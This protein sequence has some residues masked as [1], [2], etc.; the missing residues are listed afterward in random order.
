MIQTK[1]GGQPGNIWSQKNKTKLIAL[2]SCYLL[3]CFY[4]IVTLFLLY[5]IILSEAELA[6]KGEADG[7]KYYEMSV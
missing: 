7:N 1:F 5:I 2:L 6:R 4:Y 3:Y